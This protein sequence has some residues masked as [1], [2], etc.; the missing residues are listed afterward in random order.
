[1][2]KGKIARDSGRNDGTF[3]GG[4]CKRGGATQAN[5]PDNKASRPLQKQ[6]QQQIPHRRPRQNAPG[7]VRDDIVRVDSIDV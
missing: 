2:R 3:T 1:M 5:L 6:E 7:R 4:K